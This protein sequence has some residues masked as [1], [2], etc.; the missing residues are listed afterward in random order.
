VAWRPGNG[1]ILDEKIHP[2]SPVGRDHQ[3]DPQPLGAGDFSGARDRRLAR[4]RLCGVIAGDAATTTSATPRR[5]STML[6]KLPRA[7]SLVLVAAIERDEDPH[8]IPAAADRDSPRF[9]NGA[10]YDSLRPTRR[11]AAGEDCMS[12]AVKITRTDQLPAALRTAAAKSDD[13]AKTRRL[14]GDRDG[15]GGSLAA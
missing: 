8:L 10:K 14:L 13:A 5:P 4:L 7:S 1:W 2:H 11:F 3:T 9:P 15:A 12:A 6:R